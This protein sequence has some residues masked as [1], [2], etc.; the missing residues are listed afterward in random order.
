M[1]NEE[2]KI[3]RVQLIQNLKEQLTNTDYMVI[4]SLEGRAL[5]DPDI[6][7]KRQLWREQIATLEVMTDA[8][9]EEYTEP[10]VESFVKDVPS[11]DDIVSQLKELAQ[12]QVAE[13][14]DDEAKKVPALFPLWETEKAYAVGDRVWY[15]ASLYKCI[16]AHTSQ[17]TW[18]PK[19]TPALWA[20]VSEESQEADG[21]REHP[22]AW[23]SGM[24]SYNGKYYTENGI[25]YLCTRDSG[26]PLYFPISSL[27]GTYFQ[28][29][30]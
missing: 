19:D 3:S 1:E 2:I 26:N 18:N 21:S 4:K 12:A 9:Y 20:N 24:T 22:Y 30:E 6:F 29:A 14:T 27:I 13:L 8:E 17:S 10:E 23:E 25:L 28:I 16:Q 5:D 15:Q 7:A 11:A